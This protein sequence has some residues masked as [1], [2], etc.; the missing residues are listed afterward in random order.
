MNPEKNLLNTLEDMMPD[1]LF[2]FEGRLSQIS[3]CFLLKKSH[4]LDM[5]VGLS[6]MHIYIQ[7]EKKKKKKHQHDNSNCVF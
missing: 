2:G 1:E 3:S 6:C 4:L 5:Y 7:R